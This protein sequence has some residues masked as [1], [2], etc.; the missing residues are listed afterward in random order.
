L[1]LKIR[2]VKYYINNAIGLASKTRH[3][4]HLENHHAIELALKTRP[5]VELRLLYEPYKLHRQAIGLASKIRPASDQRHRIGFEDP[6]IEFLKPTSRTA[7]IK[8]GMSPCDADPKHTWIKKDLITFT[9]NTSPAGEMEGLLLG[10]CMHCMSTIAFAVSSQEP[11]MTPA[12]TTA[13]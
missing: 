6:T 7:E 11:P 9:S 3:D 8:H 2:P 1:A 13:S 12:T 4:C 5:V 10:N